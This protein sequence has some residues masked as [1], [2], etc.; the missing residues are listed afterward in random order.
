MLD[1]IGTNIAVRE[2]KGIYQTI[3]K[4]QICRTIVAQN[5][6]KYSVDR[7]G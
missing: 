5:K 1:N 4:I 3:R 2:E 6:T 7:R